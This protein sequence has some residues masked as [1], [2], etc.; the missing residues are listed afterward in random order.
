MATAT[1]KDPLLSQ[2]FRYVQS[3]W[4]TEVAQ[5]LLPH[6]NCRTVFTIEQGCL[7]WGI[8]VVVPQN[9][10]KTV[11]DELHRDHPEIVR[12]KEAACSYAWWEGIDEDIEALVKSCKS[13][14][15]VR[16]SPPMSPL[17]PWLWL[18]KPWQQIHVDF[19]GPFQG[20]MYLLV[21][22]AHLK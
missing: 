18:T 12:M 19:A 21:S 2:V 13:C 22:D 5:D 4:P 10:Q 8:C 17:L 20:R 9:W 1:K 14:Q 15:T 16:N 7:L 3:S 6:W 11:L